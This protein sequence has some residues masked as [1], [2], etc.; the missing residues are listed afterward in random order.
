VLLGSSTGGGKTAAMLTMMQNMARMG[1]SCAMLQLELSLQQMDERISAGLANVNSDII[2]N[3]AIPP[4]TQKRISAAWEEFHEDCVNARSRF[5]VYAPSAQTVQGC[6]MIF[7]QYPYRV[8]FIDYVSLINLDGEDGK[9][10]GWQKLSK[11]TKSF[12]ALAKKYGICIVL[13]VQ[14]NIDN[15]GNIEVRYAKAMKEDADIVIVW[16]MTEEAK[17]EGVVWWKHLKARQYE[18]FDFPVRIALEHYRF[19]SFSERDMPEKKKRTLGRKKLHKKD[20]VDVAME[21][22]GAF[23]KKKK[24]LV[25]EDDKPMIDAALAGE[26]AFMT[27]K[28]KLSI[29]EDDEAG[30]EDYD[31]ED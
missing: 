16:H 19:E 24:P 21:D 27:A 14:V 6:E 20:D 7:K 9:L 11:I 22:K 10:D 1:T 15:D 2:R 13:S 17:D 4:K 29:D 3:G 26:V 8:W 25:V 23:Q 28:N 30:Y 12:K 31:D 5:T 18:A